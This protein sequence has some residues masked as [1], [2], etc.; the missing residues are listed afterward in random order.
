[1]AVVKNLMVR[2]GAD[3]SAI[4]TQ[5]NKAKASMSGMQTSVSKSCGKMTSSVRSMGKV[6]AAIGATLSV[7]AIVGFSKSAK[8][9]YDE[10]TE[11]SAKLAQVMKNTMGARAGEVESIEALIDAQER[12]GVVDGAVQTEAAQE[13]ATYLTLSK[14]LKTLIPVMNDMVAQQY[15]IGASAESAVSIATMMGKVMNGQTSALSRYGYSFTAAQEAVLKFGTEEQRA[16]TLAQVVE[17]SVGGMNAALAATPNGRLEQVNFTLGKIQE[18]FGKAVSSVATTFLPALNVVCSVLANLATLANRV[19]Q[20]MANVF[21]GGASQSVATVV[22]YT[23]A[24]TGEMEDL[25]DATKSAGKAAEGLGTFGFDTLQ[26]ISGSSSSGGGSAADE[27]ASAGGGS[28]GAITETAGSAG[29]AAESVGWLEKGLNRLK[30]TMD[31]LDFSKLSGACDR[32]KTSLEPLNAT[33][34]SGLKWGYDNVLEPLAKW[35]IEDAIPSFLDTLGASASAVSPALQNLGTAVQPLVSTAFS[36]LKWAYDNVFI[37]FASW[38]GAELAPAFLNALGAAADVL[39]AAVAALQPMA[40][41]LWDNFLQPIASWTGGAIVTVLGGI[42]TALQGVS[43]WIS[44]NQGL[45]QTMT[46]IVAAFF[47]AWALTSVAE[48]LV[49][50]GGIPGV[51]ATVTGAL[52]ACTVDKIADKAETL[53][54]CALYAKDWAVAL[55]G[56]VVAIGK[57]IAAWIALRAE[58]IAGKVAL[59]ASTAAQ[60][61]HTAAS[62]AGTAATTALGVALNVLTSPITLVIAAIAALVAG[63]VL[64]VQNWDTVKA[65][66]TAAW[67]MIKGAW[68]SAGEWFSTNVIEPISNGFKGLVNGVI[69]FFEGLGNAGVGA[70]NGIIGALNGVSFDVPDWVPAIGGKTFGFNIPEIPRISLPRLAEGT[71]LPGGHPYAAIVNDQTSGVN[72]EAPLDTIKQAVSEVLS[73][74]QWLLKITAGPGLPRYLSYELER[75]GTRRGGRAIG[76]NA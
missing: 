29:E 8:A 11:A 16:A 54:I 37:P 49:C 46:G 72:V 50:A 7:G 31:S 36:G 60:V 44:E 13:L 56:N 6:F 65:A 43:S 57:D 10:Q 41:W 32:L 18:N 66:G 63:I 26:K 45:V 39:S 76:G 24:A 1:M 5:A 74:V 73:S 68:N 71:V 59:L 19:A 30:Q 17:E 27:T 52:Q 12:L 61:A 62:W 25:T 22:G 2:A 15:G 42:T 47:A 21:G 70:V 48:F 40:T 58:W 38:A 9:A 51:L 33:L 69:G 28:G 34:F 23:A 64:L 35:T 4:T 3:F 55:A 75:E 20:S 67:E 14:S 53:A